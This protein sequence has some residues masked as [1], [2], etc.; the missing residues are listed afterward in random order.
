MV[1]RTGQA[2][3]YFYYPQAVAA[4]VGLNAMPIR[5]CLR[6][7]TWQGRCDPS[8]VRMKRRGIPT[9]RVMSKHAPAA[10]TLRTM[11]VRVPPLTPIVA[12]VMTRC[13]ATTRLSN[14]AARVAVHASTICNVPLQLGQRYSD[15]S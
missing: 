10:D 12:G 14:I 8:A 11:Q 2:R 5:V 4:P 6:Q 3:F 9:L 7:A 15:I 1:E 13:R